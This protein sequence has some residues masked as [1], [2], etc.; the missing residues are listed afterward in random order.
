MGAMKELLASFE[1][2]EKFELRE[3]QARRISEMSRL[4]HG[5]IHSRISYIQEQVLLF[6]KNS[7]AGATDYDIQQYFEDDRSTYRT[8]RAE[9]CAMGR[10]RNSG[11]TRLQAGSKRTV[12][13]YV[14]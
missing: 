13:E 8:R 2:N 12:W 11:R 7:P 14:I 9:L 10:I 3:R 4:A 1:M 5:R 6:L